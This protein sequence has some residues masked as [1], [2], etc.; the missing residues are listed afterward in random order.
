[1][2]GEDT[3]RLRLLRAMNPDFAAAERRGERWATRRADVVRG[4]EGKS[5]RRYPERAFQEDDGPRNHCGSCPFP[6]GCMQCDLPEN[7]AFR[8]EFGSQN[9]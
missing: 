2:P 4:F 6:E 8:K 5:Y 1:M 7:H 3:G 9:L